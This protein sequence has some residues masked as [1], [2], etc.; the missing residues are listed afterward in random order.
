VIPAVKWQAIFAIG[1]LVIVVIAA[2]CTDEGS[3]VPVPPPT[4]AVLPGQALVATGDVTGDGIAGGTIDTITFTVGLAPG[5]GPVD[6]EKFSIYYADTIVT[7]TLLPVKGFH[8]DPGQGEWSIL[9]VNNQVGNANDRLEDNEQAVIRINPRAYLPANR[10]CTI[11][12]MSPGSTPLTI[13]RIAPPV[14]LQ[15]NNILATV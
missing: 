11:V 1:I 13:R 15:T 2:G 10:V 3:Q 8:G 4:D 7:E 12:V 9:R 14:I 6:M 5:T